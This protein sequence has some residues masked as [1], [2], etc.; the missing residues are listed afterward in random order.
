MHHDAHMQRAL[1][2]S[3]LRWCG[4]HN[5]LVFF[6]L[7]GQFFLMVIH[8]GIIDDR[9]HGLFHSEAFKQGPSSY[10]QMWWGEMSKWGSLRQCLCISMF[11]AYRHD[12]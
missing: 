6:K 11:F 2:I 10:A 5:V 7:E 9:D 4:S 3:C 8:Q 1:R 12:R